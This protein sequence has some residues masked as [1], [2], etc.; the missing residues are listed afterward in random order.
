MTREH[1][2]A[3]VVGFGLIL[4]VG[5]LIADHF[6]TDQRGHDTLIPAMAVTTPDDITLLPNPV[7]G[8]DLAHIDPAPDGSGL[9]EAEEGV[10]ITLADHDEMDTIVV[11]DPV[12]TPSRVRTSRRTH[13]VAAGD[14]LE[15]LAQRYYGDRARWP[16]IA[17]ANGISNPARMRRD[18][19]LVIP[20]LDAAREPIPSRTREPRGASDRPARSIPYEVRDGDSL[21]RIAKRELG[22][23]GRWREIK[24]LNALA[25][26][27]VHPGQVLMLP[28]R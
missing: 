5:I 27:T 12:R 2:L 20:E 7:A 24:K 25:N 4:F 26:E 19:V 9:A 22:R 13:R 21:A 17:E 3:L 1:K 14:K 8:R 11:P 6:A 16:L 18:A 28:S 15:D 10:V 23:E